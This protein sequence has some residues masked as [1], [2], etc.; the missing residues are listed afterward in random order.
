MEHK[1]SYGPVINEYPP[2]IAQP[3]SWITVR[4][5]RL[6]VMAGKSFIAGNRGRE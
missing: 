6:A 4:Q 1:I 2:N 3:L 5:E